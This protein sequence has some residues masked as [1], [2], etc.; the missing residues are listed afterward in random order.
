MHG[1]CVAMY[2]SEHGY[3]K[4]QVLVKIFSKMILIGNYICSRSKSGTQEEKRL[5]AT[6]KLL[7]ETYQHVF[8]LNG[9]NNAAKYNLIEKG[10][11]TSNEFIRYII[12]Q[13]ISVHSTII[14]ST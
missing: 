1:K 8:S 11:E 9:K 2:L 13:Y 6:F 5:L 14:R 10:K 12:V 4:L 3:R 7:M